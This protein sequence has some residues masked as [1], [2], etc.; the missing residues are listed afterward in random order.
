LL[1]VKNAEMT[2]FYLQTQNSITLST[3][4]H[5]RYYT[6]EQVDS[7]VYPVPFRSVPCWCSYI[8]NYVDVH[9][10]TNSMSNQIY[11]KHPL[12]LTVADNSFLEGFYEITETEGLTFGE[13]EAWCP[14]TNQKIRVKK[15]DVRSI[16]NPYFQKYDQPCDRNEHDCE[17]HRIKYDFSKNSFHEF[18]SDDIEEFFTYYCRCC[19]CQNCLQIHLWDCIGVSSQTKNY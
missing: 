7:G 16:W 15:T 3:L 10:W 13:G 1:K 8:G 9:N 11:V 12:G 5:G 4:P 18:F 14:D 2:F 6:K 17:L 19:R